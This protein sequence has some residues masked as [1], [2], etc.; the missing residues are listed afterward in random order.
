[1]RLGGDEVHPVGDPAGVGQI[2]QALEG[3][4][5]VGA[6]RPTHDDEPVGRVAGLA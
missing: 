5:A 1:V 4:L 3:F 6:T 2:E